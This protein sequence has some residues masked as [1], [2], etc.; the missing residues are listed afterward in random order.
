MPASRHAPYQCALHPKSDIL[1]ALT[2]SPTPCYPSPSTLLLRQTVVETTITG[3]SM[4]SKGAAGGHPSGA[5][6]ALE[7]I[8][9]KWSF[10][11]VDEDVWEK[12]QSCF[13][14]MKSFPE[15]DADLSTMTR[16]QYYYD[17]LEL[18]QHHMEKHARTKTEAI[19]DVLLHACRKLGNC[20][21]WYPSMGCSPFPYDAFGGEGYGYLFV[22]KSDPG[23]FLLRFLLRELNLETGAP[24]PEEIKTAICA[25]T[26]GLLYA[27]AISPQIQVDYASMKYWRSDPMK[28]GG[29]QYPWSRRR[30][31]CR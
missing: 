31:R 5:P 23:F 20:R 26:A 15:R 4:S 29:P 30:R 10:V 9:G 7:Y 8:V 2:P 1:F 3:A 24:P 17:P 21:G 16:F 27:T 6:P 28:L 12:A 13:Q 18:L 11:G 25:A 19:L 22:K 14:D